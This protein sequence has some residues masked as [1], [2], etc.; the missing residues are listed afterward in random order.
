MREYLCDCEECLCLNFLS[1]VK[2]TSKIIENKNN[3]T[4]DLEDCLLVEENY[5]IKVY[6]TYSFVAV[7]SCNSSEPIYFIKIVEQNVAKENLRDQFEQETFPGECYLKGFYFQKSSSKT[8][9][10][11]SFLFSTMM[12][13]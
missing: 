10:S 13:I 2:N 8:L 12:S 6:E 7:I 3:D 9:T 4:D 11:K 5:P 1:C